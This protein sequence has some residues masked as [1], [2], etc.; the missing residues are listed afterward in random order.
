MDCPKCGEDTCIHPTLYTDIG[1]LML[2]P[3]SFM[4]A[5]DYHRMRMKKADEK[6]LGSV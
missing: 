1:E 2:C 4:L 3:T 5:D 6:L